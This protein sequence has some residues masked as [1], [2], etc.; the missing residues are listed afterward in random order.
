MYIRGG[1]FL[2]TVFPICIRCK[3]GWVGGLKNLGCANYMAKN[4]TYFLLTFVQI[5]GWVGGSV[6]IC[7]LCKLEKTYAKMDHPLH[8]HVIHLRI[9]P[10]YRTDYC[11][12]LLQN[13]LKEYTYHLQASECAYSEQPLHRSKHAFVAPEMTWI[14]FIYWMKRTEAREDFY[15]TLLKTRICDTMWLTSH[16]TQFLSGP[17]GLAT[18]CLSQVLVLSFD[19]KWYLATQATTVTFKMMGDQFKT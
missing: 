14:S 12:L 8:S 1:P 6:W 5:G 13:I 18:H 19:C 9:W 10:T 15:T 3:L 11:N 7:I 4:N 16:K 17:A 2:C